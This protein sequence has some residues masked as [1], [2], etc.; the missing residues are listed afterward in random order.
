[1]MSE[2]AQIETIAGESLAVRDSPLW[3]A[4]R[5]IARHEKKV[6][7]ALLAKEICCFLPVISRL[8][9]WSDRQRVI[10]EPLFAGYVFARIAPRST[11][12]IAL[13]ET[14]G[15][16]GLVGERGVGTPIPEYEI[17]AIQ[18]IL[19][20]RVAV[21]P[22]NFLVVGQRVRIRGGALDGLEGILRS[23]KGDQSLIVSLESIKRSISLTI[24][25]YEVESIPQ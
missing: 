4:V 13:L 3:Y 15:V 11:T 23:I 14:K 6:S 17:V 10:D 16:V 25:G 22:H 1:M 9:Q 18:K 7:S 8:R 20:N 5:T 12:R 21:A 19:E 2:S 24:S